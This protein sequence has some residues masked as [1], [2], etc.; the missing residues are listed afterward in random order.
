MLNPFAAVW[1]SLALGSL[2]PYCTALSELAA[3]QVS[4][5]RHS[6]L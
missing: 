1:I 2:M 6:F 4:S 3:G 5:L